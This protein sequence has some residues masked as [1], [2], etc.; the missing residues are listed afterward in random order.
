MEQAHRWERELGQ[1]A[2]DW[3]GSGI[4]EGKKELYSRYI[5]GADTIGLGN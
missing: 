2:V 3:G 4:G 1:V 5:L